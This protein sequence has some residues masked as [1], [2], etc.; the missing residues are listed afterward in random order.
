LPNA[1]IDSALG[2][3]DNS[4]WKKVFSLRGKEKQTL[5]LRLSDIAADWNSTISTPARAAIDLMALRHNDGSINIDALRQAAR[6]LTIL[7]DL[8]DCKDVTIGFVNLHPLLLALGLAYDSDAARA[9]GASLAALITA[10]CYATS[11]ELACLRGASDDF[12]V[13]RDSVMRSLRNHHRAVYGDRNDYEKLSVLPSAL[14]LKNCPDLAL[15]AEAQRRWDEA[16]EMARA[17]GLR[18]IQVTDLTPSPTLAML[19]NSASQGIEPIHS[20]MVLRQRDS[21]LYRSFLNPVVLEALA[22]L[23]Y[24]RTLAAAVTEHIAGARKLRRSPII[25]AR[26]LIARGLTS[27]ALEKIED[28]VPNVN[29]L[30]LAITPW[31]IGIDFCVNHLNIPARKLESPRFD[32]L[33]HL[34]FSEAD[35]SAANLHCYGHGT[36]RNAKILELRHR[37]V[38]AC[39]SEISAEARLRMAS[40]LQG[41]I[42]GNTGAAIFLPL[43]SSLEKEVEVTLSAWRSGLK[44]FSITLDPDIVAPAARAAENSPRRLT[45]S[46]HAHA[47]PMAPLARHSRS[48]KSTSLLATKKPMSSRRTAR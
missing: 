19:M 7:F 30:Q 21:D 48:A 1:A 39:G 22:R 11:A 8:Q 9:M 34:G 17:F 12:A 3:R 4:L 14:P 28:Y 2:K 35:V 15:A 27:A 25:N 18:A 24:P 46:A 47:K 13:T 20:L 40:A 42:S 5:S 10:E 29:A 43:Q 31:I 36:L 32:L 26:T 45:T 6:L 16:L 23:N 41:F 44:E 38:F 37:P 33:R